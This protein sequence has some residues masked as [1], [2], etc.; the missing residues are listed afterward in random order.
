MRVLLLY[1]FLGFIATLYILGF[2]HLSF[3]NH[4]WLMSSTDMTSDLI[5]WKYYKEDIWR[6]PIASNPNYGMDIASGIVFSGAVP[7]LSVIFKLFSDLLPYNFHFFSLWI[8]ICFFLQSYIAFL[9]IH[10]K[11]KNLSFS[12]L[13][14]LFFLLSPIF[15]HRIPMHLSLSAHWLI[16]LGIYIEIKTDH[17]K[18]L[19]Y[20]TSLILLSALTHFYFTMILFGMFILFVLNEN[21][22]KLNIKKLIIQISLPMFFLILTMYIFGFFEVPYTDAL[23]YGYGHYKLNLASIIN[24]VSESPKNIISWSLILPKISTSWGERIE[25]FS[26]LGIGGMIL[27]IFGILSTF[28]NFKEF[29][30]KKYRPYFIIV[31]LFT[32]LALTNRISYG[33]NVLIEFEL[34]KYIYGIMSLIRASGRLFWPVYYL[35]FF[36]SIIML[37]KNFSKKKSLYIL[38]LIFFLQVIDIYPGLKKYFNSNAFKTEKNEIDTLF[39][40]KLSEENQILKTT[41]LNN[42]THFLMSLKEILISKNFDR[43]DIAKHARYNRKKASI[44]RSNL[45]KSFDAGIIEKNTIFVIDNKNHLRNLKYLFENKDVGFFLKE[46]V[47]VFVPDKK[48]EMSNFDKNELDKYGPL[49]FLKK[50]KLIFKFKDEQSIHGFGWSHNLSSSSPGMWTEGNISTLLFRFDNKTNEDYLIKIK[51]GSLIAEKDKPVNFSIN[52]NDL[53]NQKFSLK[54][55]NDLDENSIKLK[56]NKD[57]IN[58]GIHYIKFLIDNPISPLELFESPDARKLGLLVESME[59]LSQ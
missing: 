23:G 18:K 11:T 20:W 36:G 32:A 24:P 57:Q 39:W 5:S 25:G 31:I 13:G 6:F 53:Y 55:I 14:S 58:G 54:S 28:F 9:I 26:Y 35:L 47:W 46:K 15:I 10:Q 30:K 37:Y 42:E 33:S 34:P 21:L 1:I 38:L 45:Y 16:L 4:H 56:I 49:N 40:N 3:T 2:D 8:F 19:F 44:S 22:I 7:F 12:I 51:L 41:Y 17:S 59:I 29:K 50:D 48:E 52:I 43:T 27:L